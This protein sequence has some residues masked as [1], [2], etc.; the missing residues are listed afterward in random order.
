MEKQQKASLK[1]PMDQYK[2]EVVRL[3]GGGIKEIDARARV[4]REGG[5]SA[6]R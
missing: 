2:S 5:S 1:H 4:A 3:S 6:G